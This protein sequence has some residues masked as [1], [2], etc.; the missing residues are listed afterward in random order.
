MT[1][2][3]RPGDLEADRETAVTLLARHVNP[4]YSG[5]RFDWLYRE[6]PAGL[7]RLW[8]AVD[9]S[10]GD[11]IGSAGA[12]PRRMC[13][14]G[15]SITAWVLGDL[16]IDEQHR[17]LGPAVQLQR[18]CLEEIGSAG[19]S[20]WYDF[21]SRSMEAVYRRLGMT[22]PQG[23]LVRLAR[24]LRLGSKLRQRL[25]VS[26]LS[27]GV[28]AAVDLALAC[29]ARPRRLSRSLSI[30][31]H[32]GAYHEEFS[33]LAGLVNAHYGLCSERSAGYLN[34]RYHDNPIQPHEALCVRRGGVLLAYVVL[35]YEEGDTA[36]VVDLFGIPDVSLLRAL[37]R[38]AAA[39]AW[40]RGAATVSISLLE[41]HP[42]IRLV[43]QLGFHLR[44]AA[45]VYLRS[46]GGSD[47]SLVADIPWFLTLGDRDA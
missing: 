45:P 8:I 33:A 18:T 24:P 27:R 21:P 19:G 6:N 10:T 26:P 35:A 15:R 7:G 30:A 13:V 34:W 14:Q 20:F 43:R 32:E 40:Y 11:P 12:F 39:R 44:D 23:R 31:P 5:R 28:G 38:A 37:L 41:S 16:C 17:S 36:T 1:V 46:T 29:A 42:W 2:K 9:S 22:A 25:G 3:I 4:G 47:T